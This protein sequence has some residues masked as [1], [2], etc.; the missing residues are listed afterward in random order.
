[1]GKTSIF[2]LIFGTGIDGGWIWTNEGSGIGTIIQKG[3][4][5]ANEIDWFDLIN[6]PWWD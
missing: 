4:I 3:S 5:W 2:D 6:P 1:M